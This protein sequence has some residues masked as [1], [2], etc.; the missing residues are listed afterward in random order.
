MA[1]A[2]SANAWARYRH[3]R[4]FYFVYPAD[5]PNTRKLLDTG[6][7]GVVQLVCI[8]NKAHEAFK[9]GFRAGSRRKGKSE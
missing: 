9:A 6:K 3:D 7:Y 1:K 2:K 4:N 5:R 8:E